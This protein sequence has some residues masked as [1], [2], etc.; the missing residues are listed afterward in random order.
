MPTSCGLESW[1][2]EI[3]CHLKEKQTNDLYLTLHSAVPLATNG[4][5]TN[6]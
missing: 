3:N 1:I 4:A 2:A 5:R 6:R